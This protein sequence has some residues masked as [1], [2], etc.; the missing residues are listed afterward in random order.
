MLIYCPFATII[1]PRVEQTCDMFGIARMI[2]AMFVLNTFTS[3]SVQV[4]IPSEFKTILLGF[5]LVSES[6]YMEFL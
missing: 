6:T 3:S 2:G 4:I 5:I 1:P